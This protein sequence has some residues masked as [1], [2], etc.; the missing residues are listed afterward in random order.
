M[1]KVEFHSHRSRLFELRT[2]LL[3][4]VTMIEEELREDVM[5]AGD[6]S[7]VSSHPADQDV[8]GLDEQV[9]LAQN[10]EELL[11]D[12]DAALL[13]IEAGTYGNCQQCGRPVSKERLNAMPH[14]PW[15]IVCA[16]DHDSQ[17][18]PPK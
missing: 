2:R 7:P 8:E 11:E 9:I 12:V 5:A 15:C 6:P 14:T 17:R 18:R 4:E 13:R 16:H 10:E 1:S 3:R